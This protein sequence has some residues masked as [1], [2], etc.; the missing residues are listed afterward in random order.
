VLSDVPAKRE[1]QLRSLAAQTRFR[2]LASF[3]NGLPY[4]LERPMGR[5]RVLFVASSVSPEWNTLPKTYAMAV[6]DRILRSMVE[7]TLPQHNFPPVEEIEYPVGD[8]RDVDFALY[9]P[10]RELAAEAVD[11][12]YVGAEKRAVTIQNALARGVYQLN[13]YSPDRG[14]RSGQG[15]KLKWKTQFAVNGRPVESELTPLTRDQFDERQ[16]GDRLRWIGPGETISLAGSQIRGQNWWQY[17]VLAVLLVL[18][19]ELL[20]LGWPVF[21]QKQEQS[22]AT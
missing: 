1:R 8:D 15:R 10:G 6:F 17:L 19:V 3:D 20:V 21:W 16:L 7:S 18:L 9:R 14:D 13:A 2:V 12:G 4:L 11:A 5:G 22:V